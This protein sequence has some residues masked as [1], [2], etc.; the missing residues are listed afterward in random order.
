MSYNL[1][2]YYG[3]VNDS[4]S[5]N[6][7]FRTIIKS[8]LPD[9]LATGEMASDATSQ[10]FLT[11]V[12]K[13]AST[14]YS[15]APFIKGYD[16]NTSLYYRDD[17]YTCNTNLVIKTS[18]RDINHYILTH[19]ETHDTLHLFVLHLK[20]SSGQ[21]NEALRLAET[22]SLRKVTDNLPIHASYIVCGDFNF[23]NDSEP[24]Y[25]KLLAPNANNLGHVIDPITMTGVWNRGTYAKY[26]TQSPR[27]RS[28]GGG[29]T[30]GMDDRFDLILFSPEM[31]G[32]GAI[33]YI[34]GSTHAYGNDGNHYNDSINQQPN[35]AVV[36][37]VADALHY[38]ADHLP[39]RADFVFIHAK[40]NIGM[41]EPFAT[42]RL[43]IYPNP[44]T[45]EIH[46]QIPSD[47]GCG[48]LK[49]YNQMGVLVLSK[50]ADELDKGELILSIA[51]WTSGGY[52]VTLCGKTSVYTGS[53]FKY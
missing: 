42:N 33:Q 53:F 21:A 25:K 13:Q 44:A 36:A 47:M 10:S 39:V 15:R 43:H 27:V 19:N 45:E 38:A 51:H 4:A 29:I 40:G 46:I 17:K 6:P 30:G 1:L 35:T 2:N 12:M 34:P 18:L 31:N 48:L 3:N 20:A 8:T 26:H 14:H 7:H 37:P 41:T 5:R 23:Y 24:A 22:D 32:V 52:H 9:I 11:D 50:P 28:F 16:T 49:I